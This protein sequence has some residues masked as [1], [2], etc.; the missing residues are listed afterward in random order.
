M[1]QAGSRRVL[2]FASL[3][4]FVLIGPTGWARDARWA[5]LHFQEPPSQEASE[6]DEASTEPATGA[7]EKPEPDWERLFK[8]LLD[9][10]TDELQ[11]P[12]IAGKIYTEGGPEERQR[13]RS[14][15]HGPERV[16][17]VANAVLNGLAFAVEDLRSE[18]N[19]AL[20]GDFLTCVAARDDER[21]QK[22]A[23]RRILE[24]FDHLHDSGAE[25]Q[26]DAFALRIREA[27]ASMTTPIEERFGAARVAAER[28]DLSAMPVLLSFL[29]DV[30][31]DESVETH[32]RAA[33]QQRVIEILRQLTGQ[34]LAATADAW[35]AWWD[36]FTSGDLE[37]WQE[38][39]RQDRIGE[40]LRASRG[41][42][43]QRDSVII[44]LK[45]RQL[46]L[47]PELLVTPGH[48][49]FDPIDPE[50]RRYAAQK[51]DEYA[52]RNNGN[53]TLRSKIEAAL[54]AMLERLDAEGIPE[55]RQ[56]LIDL[57]GHYGT[58]SV[59]VRDLLLDVVRKGGLEERSVAIMAL[60]NFTGLDVFREL[61]ALLDRLEQ[62]DEP[63]QLLQ[64]TLKALPRQ[65]ANSPDLLDNGE[66]RTIRKQ[67]GASLLSFLTDPAIEGKDF[68]KEKILLRTLTSFPVPEAGSV[69]QRILAD[70]RDERWE[71]RIEAVRCTELWADLLDL[72][73]RKLAIDTLLG[74]LNEP[75]P[76][77]R[78]E[79]FKQ[80]KLR[81]FDKIPPELASSFPAWS[82][83][84]ADDLR[85]FGWGVWG[86]YQLELLEQLND[87]QSACPAIE[88]LL[89][90]ME[91]PSPGE[92]ATKFRKA[93]KTCI[94]LRASELEV[95][96]ITAERL[97]ADHAFAAAILC[98]ELTKKIG[99]VD[100]IPPSEEMA[101]GN[102]SWRA[103]VQLARAW[104]A[105]RENAQQRNA[106]QP[107]EVLIQKRP[108]TELRALQAQGL[109]AADKAAEA[110]RILEG[111]LVERE[112]K[113]IKAQLIETLHVIGD[114]PSRERAI[115]LASG[116]WS[117]RDPGVLEWV[118]Q[119]LIE[120]GTPEATEEAI[121]IYT[122][123]FSMK[124][125]P[126]SEDWRRRALLVEVLL[127]RGTESSLQKAAELI[128]EK[129]EVPE[130]FAEQFQ[131]LRARLVALREGDSPAREE[132]DG[133]GDG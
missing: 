132:A 70:K 17:A 16:S 24:E 62:R 55:V 113:D 65:V 31:E 27:I 121:A 11:K 133:G 30:G 91:P 20:L 114:A 19:E 60:S 50:I 6:Q 51:L 126:D 98:D 7:Q 86:N 28:R 76:D 92:D 14:F 129:K 41:A 112:D 120:K 104:L 82:K 118:A 107:L 78:L 36:S 81:H 29:G 39:W 37:A 35:R 42:L 68:Q 123:L 125:A 124:D 97:A 1:N 106:L 87:P 58:K 90:R 4:L 10:A 2:S 117:D 122:Q 48:G 94:S 57:L 43:A 44:D 32:V 49:L 15:L 34:R 45:K 54:P 33:H 9:P 22:A 53:G 95:V 3:L 5:V 38:R 119:G 18:E 12:P 61:A 80:L 56:S 13:L 69:I 88:A 100:P 23:L 101:E 79:C 89:A 26:V 103:K 116:D 109:V 115:E 83:I 40:V 93:A 67:V 59:A 8:A 66:F 21:L 47:S 72:S 25:D 111:L 128:E 71:V 96:L 75:S 102:L 46:E 73:G 105:C 131:K 127:T 99:P 85:Q 63:A 84:L 74:A 108:D 52:G 64:D 77:V 130:P 110:V